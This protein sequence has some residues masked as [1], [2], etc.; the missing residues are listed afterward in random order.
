MI[1]KKLPP[2]LLVLG[3]EK[4]E[5]SDWIC[6]IMSL[7]SKVRV[8]SGKVAQKLRMLVTSIS[9]EVRFVAFYCSEAIVLS[10][11]SKLLSMAQA[12]KRNFPTTWRSFVFSFL[13]NRGSVLSCW[14][15]C[16]FL[17]YTGAVYGCEV[18]VK[19]S[20]NKCWNWKSAFVT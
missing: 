15:I 8:A 13:S 3:S 6:K 10:P 20:G 12:Q 2:L 11:I 18:I 17:P 14:A 7:A 9:L 5:A 19:P 1:R 16:I 4:K